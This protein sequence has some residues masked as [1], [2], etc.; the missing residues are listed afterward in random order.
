MRNARSLIQI[1]GRA[2]RNANGKAVF[3]ADRITEAMK[4]CMDDN[5]E[6]R[7]IQ[8]AYNKKHG[9]VPRTIIKPISEPIHGHDITNAVEAI[10]AKQ[11][12]TKSG[13]KIDKKAKQEIIDDIRNQMNQAAKELDYERAIELR[14]ILLELQETK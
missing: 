9:I 2:A 12:K 8:L 4:I 5:E 7:R 3:Y 14:N 6:K 1:T 11:N 10:L 13:D